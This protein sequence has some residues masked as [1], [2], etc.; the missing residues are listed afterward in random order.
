MH[1]VR[2]YVFIPDV[3]LYVLFGIVFPFGRPRATCISSIIIIIIMIGIV[4]VGGDV[5]WPS[6]WDKTFFDSWSLLYVY[7]IPSFSLKR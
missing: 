3:I 6:I 4:D 1:A 2:V 5:M 7:A